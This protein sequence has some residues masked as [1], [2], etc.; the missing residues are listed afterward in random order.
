M[1]KPAVLIPVVYRPAVTGKEWCPDAPPLRVIPHYAGVVPP[2]EGDET[3]ALVCGY[4]FKAHTPYRNGDGPMPTSWVA[5]PVWTGPLSVTGYHGGRSSSCYSVRIL[6]DD[7]AEPVEGLMSCST[8][9]DVLPRMV[10]GTIP[11]GRWT[12]T[13]RGQNYMIES[14]GGSRA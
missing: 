9:L 5:A 11:S 12:A 4:G 8:F 6:A 14:A 13:K 1:P 7:G 10:S 3:E 2:R